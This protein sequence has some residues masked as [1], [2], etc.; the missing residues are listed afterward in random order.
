LIGGAAQRHSPNA[1]ASGRSSSD[2]CG[3]VDQIRHNGSAAV[4]GIGRRVGADIQIVHVSVTTMHSPHGKCATTL[5]WFEE[6]QKENQ[7]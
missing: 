4:N 7:T 3:G 5:A 6:T 2:S 1:A